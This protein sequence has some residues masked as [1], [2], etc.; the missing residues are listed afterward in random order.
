[1]SDD[2]KDRTRVPRNVVKPPLSTG[3]PIMR[4]AE[5]VR[6]SLEPF[7]CESA[8]VRVGA[9]VHDSQQSQKCGRIRT[10]SNPCAMCT[11]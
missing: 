4:I 10:I 9:E 7:A 11:Q 1:M 2:V 6:W 3:A 8:S 5:I